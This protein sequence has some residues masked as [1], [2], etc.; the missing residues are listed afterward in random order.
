MKFAT[1][2]A[3]LT[4]ANANGQKRHH[5]IRRVQDDQSMSMMLDPNKRTKD[6]ATTRRST[7]T[8]TTTTSGDMGGCEFDLTGDWAPADDI[9]KTSFEP[10][11]VGRPEQVE[12][13]ITK[14]CNKN[15]AIGLTAEEDGTIQ[16]TYS[17][18]EVITGFGPNNLGNVRVNH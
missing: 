18:L 8:K 12:L 1:V 11:V 9:C 14:V 6:T 7:T 13:E 4:I 17:F 5:A 3:A 2:L 15:Y 16:G 10:Q